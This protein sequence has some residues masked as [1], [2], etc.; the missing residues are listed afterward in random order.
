MCAKVITLTDYEFHH[1]RLKCE[2]NFGVSFFTEIIFLEH[3][4][5]ELCGNDLKLLQVGILSVV[6]VCIYK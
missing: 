6:D 3:L 2:F 1:L 5:H 4:S